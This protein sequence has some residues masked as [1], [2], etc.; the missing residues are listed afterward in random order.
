MNFCKLDKFAKLHIVPKMHKFPLFSFPFFAD[1]HH[2]HAL[3]VLL[4]HPKNRLV[5]CVYCVTK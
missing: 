3:H 2:S 5:L 1:W 4:Y